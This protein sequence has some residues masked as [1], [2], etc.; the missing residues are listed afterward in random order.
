M[1]M[2][3]DFN[4]PP[5]ATGFGN[6]VTRSM[7]IRA[8]SS[9]A[10][11]LAQGFPTENPPDEVLLT[12]IAAIQN[13]RNFY[14]DLRGDPGLRNAVAKYVSSYTGRNWNGED[15]VTIT[16]GATEAMID[17][18]LGIVNKGD[19]VIV[20]EP[21]YEN[22]I[23]QLRL[24][25]VNVKKYTLSPPEFL[26]NLD[27][28]GSL[29]SHKTKA[30]IVNTPHN[31]TGRVFSS[32]ELDGIASLCAE[33]GTIAILDEI[34]QQITYRSNAFYSLASNKSRADQVVLISGISKIY[35]A[36]GWRVGWAVASH[37]LTSSIRRVHDFVTGAVPT[38]FQDA[39]AVALTLGSDYYESIRSK[40]NR[41]RKILEKILEE[42]GILFF[43]PQGAYYVLADISIF[44]Y[45][46]SEEFADALL[47]E[48]GVA[49]VPGSAFFEN[50]ELARRFVRITFSKNEDVISLAGERINKWINARKG[51]VDSVST[52]LT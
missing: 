20:M 18:L 2:T 24:S 17:A 52:D 48:A 14:A 19:E 33:F 9:G 5:R 12:A 49:V 26:I 1:N 6:S 38:P 40:Y 43:S 28:L 41:R 3:F 21:W 15:N 44:G 10:I 22:Y 27:R 45:R 31:P 46:T 16:C 11:N 30:I 4:P 29:F 47:E 50:P 7:S 51:R 35:A 37:E 42:V 8:A 25:E 39:A 32:K 23:P 34:Y 13:G 36:T